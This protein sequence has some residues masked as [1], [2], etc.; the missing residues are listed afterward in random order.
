MPPVAETGD[1]VL[2]FFV[3][4]LSG[5]TCVDNKTARSVLLSS[6][7][8]S[9]V[10]GAN[11]RRREAVRGRCVG[12][13]RKAGRRKHTKKALVC[14]LHRT[15]GSCLSWNRSSSILVFIGRRSVWHHRRLHGH[16]GLR[17]QHRGERPAP[18]VRRQPM[19]GCPARVT[20]RDSRKGMS[21]GGYETA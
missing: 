12:Q 21:S 4:L 18:G 2:L 20:A 15:H 5:N 14:R 11:Q 16:D 17:F 13:S 3:S 1:A 7:R 19:R 6:F 10:Q 8:L 9:V